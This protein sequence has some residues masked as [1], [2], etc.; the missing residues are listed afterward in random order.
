MWITRARKAGKLKARILG[1][2]TVRFS[3]EDIAQ[4][5]QQAAT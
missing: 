3:M 4:F 5:E 2:G 1:A